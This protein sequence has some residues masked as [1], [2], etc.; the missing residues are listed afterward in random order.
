MMKANT[1][2]AVALFLAGS[3]FLASCSST[4]LIQSVPPGAKLYLNEELVGTTPYSYT[5]TKIVGST[6]TVRLKK[7][8]YETFNTTFSRNEEVDAGAIIGGLFVWFP[9]L[10]IMKYK[11]VHTY[12]LIKKQG[13]SDDTDNDSQSVNSTSEKLDE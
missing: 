2:K 4:T 8:G 1:L 11:P 6:T 12:E 7:E 9:L 13:G 3:I 10:W 5:D